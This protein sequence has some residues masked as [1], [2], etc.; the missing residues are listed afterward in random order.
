MSTLTHDGSAAP[1]LR[2]LIVEDD[3]DNAASLAMLFHISGFE[4]EAACC[5]AAAERAVR[6]RPPDVLFID[7]GMPGEDGYAV[8]K[9]LRPHFAAKPLLVALTRHAT[10]V[11]RQRSRDEGFDHHLLKPAEPTEILRLLRNHAQQIAGCGGA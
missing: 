3:A 11:C 8:A 2:I 9:R 1:S 5:G 6:C 4:A 7:I 10:E